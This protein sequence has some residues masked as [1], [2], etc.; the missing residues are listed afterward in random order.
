MQRKKLVLFVLLIVFSLSFTIKTFADSS[1][2]SEQSDNIE[3]N[4]SSIKNTLKRVQ[5]SDKNARVSLGRNFQVILADYITPLNVRLVKNN[6]FNNELANLQNEFSELREDFSRKYVEY[7]QEL[8]LLISTSCE[9]SPAIFYDRLETTRTKRAAI[10][11]SAK[12]LNTMIKKDIEIVTNLN[13]S[14]GGEKDG[15]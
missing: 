3:N 8:E 12:K 5:N 2:S 10:I 4:C 9:E 7:S 6:I 15:E 11:D 1:I 13:E 14:L